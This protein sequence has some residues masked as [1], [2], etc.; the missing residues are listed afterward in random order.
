VTPG[1]VPSRPE[2]APPLVPRGER[3]FIDLH[4]H[5]SASF[6]SL[7]SPV[8]IVRT[9][10]ARGLTHL[11]ITD[12]GTLDGAIAARDAAL[13]AS[14]AARASR[15]AGRNGVPDGLEILVGEEIRTREGDLIGVFLT[16]AVPAGLPVFEAIDAV[17]AQ[18]GLVGIPHPFDRFRGSVGRGDA[19]VDLS[20]KV[21]WI[22]AW[23][24]RIVF[25]DGNIR[26]AELAVSV[27]K[28]GI[29]VSDAH[30]TVEVGVASTLVWGDPS[31]P[32]GLLAALA[33]P[34]EMSMGRA[35][36][37]A[38][39]ATPAAKLVKRARGR[40]TPVAR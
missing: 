24:A 10:A 7:A 33:G 35:S 39:L 4:C 14:D 38:R 25:G 8:A 17:R 22:E 37:Y 5:T 19:L 15:D 27:G 32:A 2:V 20:A 26:A 29:A 1:E 28:P 6:D 23:N 13:A 12:H 3:A 9:A 30:T 21:D 36:F 16:E 11:A 18:G 31:T 34:R 40:T